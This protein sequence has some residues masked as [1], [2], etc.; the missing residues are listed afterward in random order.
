MPNLSPKQLKRIDCINQEV[1]DGHFVPLDDTRFL[2]KV[3]AQLRS[4]LD[5]LLET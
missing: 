5:E 2:L 3:I 4:K 1:I